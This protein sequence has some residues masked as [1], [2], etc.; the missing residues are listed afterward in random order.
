MEDLRG[1]F[2]SFKY[3]DR[4]DVISGILIDFNSNLTLI[5]QNPVD[6]VIDG[7]M[8][9]K[10]NKIL[11]Y[12]RDDSEEFTEKVLLVKGL[13]PANEAFMPLTDLREALRLISDEFGA[14][15]IK[16]KDDSVCYIGKLIRTTSE[17]VEI[18]EIDPKAIWVGNGKFKLKSIRTIEFDTD[19]INSLLLYNKVIEGEQIK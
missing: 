17:F 8:L 15:L 16:N 9:L 14:I 6:Y 1:K 4:K 11:K 18:H 13:M 5:K 19:Y 3:R 10:T 12:K 2:V 7:Y